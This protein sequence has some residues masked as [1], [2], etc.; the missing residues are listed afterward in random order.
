MLRR[1]N[2]KKQIT[3]SIGN[4]FEAVGTTAVVFKDVVGIV[5]DNVSAYKVI[6]R[7]ELALELVLDMKDIAEEI[8]TN[9][10]TTKQ[11][12]DAEALLGF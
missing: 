6:S 4:V 12:S 10:I 2:T 1:N 8:K 5:A 11:L 7:K 9:K 3:A